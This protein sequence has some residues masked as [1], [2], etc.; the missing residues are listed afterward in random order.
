[1]DRI[2]NAK[3]FKNTMDRFI[4][5]KKSIIYISYFGKIKI[6]HARE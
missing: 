5:T 3:I 1:M 4:L 2:G 6:E